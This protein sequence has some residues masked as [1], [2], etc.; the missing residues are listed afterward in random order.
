MRAKNAFIAS[1][2]DDMAVDNWDGWV[3]L[4]QAIWQHVQLVGDNLFVTQVGRLQKG[5]EASVANAILIRMNQV[6]ALTETLDTVELAKKRA[7][8]CIISHRSGETEDTTI[9]NLV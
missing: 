5:I 9:A 1:I 3:Q 7:Y 4:T 6:G 8:A 2:E